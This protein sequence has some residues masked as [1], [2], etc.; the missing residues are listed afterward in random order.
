MKYDYYILIVKKD[1][2][3]NFDFDD[4]LEEVTGLVDGDILT[5]NIYRLFSYSEELI[6]E[7]M[8]EKNIKFYLEKQPRPTTDEILDEANKRGHLTHYDRLIIDSNQRD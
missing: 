6:R 3:S 5:D 2:L 8:D 4:M 7:Y 1:E